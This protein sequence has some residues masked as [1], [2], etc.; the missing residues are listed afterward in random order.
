[1]L[2]DLVSLY[3]VKVWRCMQG[4]AVLNVSQQSPHTQGAEVAQWCSFKPGLRFWLQM[5][6]WCTSIMLLILLGQWVMDHSQPVGHRHST[7]VSATEWETRRWCTNPL[8]DTSITN[9]S[10]CEETRGGGHGSRRGGVKVS[11]RELQDGAAHKEGFFKLHCKPRN[12]FQGIKVSLKYSCTPPRSA[13]ENTGNSSPL[14]FYIAR[15]TMLF[16]FS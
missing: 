5:P 8:G 6:V 3:G 9:V 16:S 14:S 12:I 7:S 15:P 4:P 1:M 10:H 13:N 11:K 2:V